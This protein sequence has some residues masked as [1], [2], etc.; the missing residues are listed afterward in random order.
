MTT[1]AFGQN[2]PVKYFPAGTLQLRKKEYAGCWLVAHRKEATATYR[3]VEKLKEPCRKC[4]NQKVDPPGGV[5]LNGLFLLQLHCV[6]EPS[7]LC[8]V[9]VSEQKLNS[10]KPDDFKLFENVAY[11]DASINSLSL[12]CFS[13]FASL[14][15]LNLSLNG[16]CNMIFDAADFPV[17]E[18]LDLSYNNLSA[19]AIV[20]LGR[21][22][23][24]KVLHLSGNQL[25]H[26][27]PN[28]G[29]PNH[30]PT[31]LP[32][33][34]EDKRFEALEIL[35]LDDNKLS[36]EVFYSLTN[37]KR[38]KYLNLQGNQI[39]NIPNMEVM[40]CSKS[41]EQAEKKDSLEE[42]RKGSNV[43]LPELQFL[44]LANNK[45][46]T[47]E[48]V[49]AASFFPMLH[50][51]DIHSNP[52]TTQRRG[53]YPL[54]TFY[55]QERLGIKIKQKKEQE[56]LKLPVKVFTDS[57]WKV[58]ETTPKVSK[59]P[60]LLN[61]ACPTQTRA[62]KCETSVKRTTGSQGKK[63]STVKENTK[64]FFMTQAEDEELEFCLPP[65]EKKTLGNNQKTRASPE[66]YTYFDMVMDAKANSGMLKPVE[67]QTAVRRLEHTLRNLNVYRDSKP[68]LDSI[69][70]PYREKEKKI[71]EM[72]PLRPIKQ[73]AERVYEM[74]KGI[75]ESRTI[76]VVALGS[77][78]HST[79]I[80]K[81][82][83]KEALALLRDMKT[84]YMMVHKKTME[85]AASLESGK[86]VAELPPVQVL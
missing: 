72:P 78:L 57:K 8:S 24:L 60:L 13:C 23:H 70:T 77:A 40:D 79:G 6:D 35:M 12:G 82:E 31:Q 63:R 58:E 32:A 43:P 41:E 53:N 19:D 44:S 2:N 5:T 20:S 83:C 51:L 1:S 65:E 33:A 69:Q 74:I 26:L 61:A 21:L 34:E 22:L 86:I 75:K 66:Q 59:R 42:D 46:A 67:I 3:T 37:L 11:I 81:E 62:D 48:A 71:K 73:P 47:E 85:Q 36:S 68:K 9:Y 25:H 15:E 16:I 56:G 28:L 27:P 50:E 54:L 45:I 39:S 55:L 29:S 4:E 76:K 7:Q 52:L 17:L 49:I 14:R 38:L 84:K 80:N 30:D 64:H 10:V 18:V